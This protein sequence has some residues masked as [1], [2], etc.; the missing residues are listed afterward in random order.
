M[1]EEAKEFFFHDFCRHSIVVLSSYL[2]NVQESSFNH[3]YM[4][5]DV[6]QFKLNLNMNETYMR[7]IING[8]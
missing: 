1:M 2:F 7:S 4:S 6:S 8:I 5:V 3:I